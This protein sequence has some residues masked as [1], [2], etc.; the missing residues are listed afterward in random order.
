MCYNV[1]TINYVF[2]LHAA[3]MAVLVLWGHN[4]K[5]LEEAWAIK[6]GMLLNCQ[7]VVVHGEIVPHD[8]K[9]KNKPAVMSIL[10]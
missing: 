10:N 1:L 5:A 9:L 4:E 7:H 8:W 3:E 2:S 6:S